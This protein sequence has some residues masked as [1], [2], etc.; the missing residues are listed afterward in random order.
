MLKPYEWKSKVYPQPL[1]K[2]NDLY[3][4]V[5]C[6]WNAKTEKYD[7]I[8]ANGYLYND[9]AYILNPKLRSYSAEYS[10]QIFLFCQHMLYCKCE[11]PFDMKLWGTI[12]N[13]RYIARQWIDEYNRMRSNGELEF[14]KKY[15]KEEEI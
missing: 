8:L 7:S 12:N 6:Y 9:A 1:N 5:C 2:V 4:K 13:N 3:Y 10:R 14:M 11:R 15:I